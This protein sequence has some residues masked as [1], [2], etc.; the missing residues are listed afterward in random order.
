MRIRWLP[1]VG[2]LVLAC[3][4][5]RAPS[6][7]ASTERNASY[8]AALE[9]ISTEE[10]QRHVAFLADEKREGREAGT[11]GGY[12]AGEYLCAQLE[13]LGLAGAGTDG[14]Y[15]QAFAPNYRNILAKLEGSD[16]ALHAEVIVVGA[17]YDHIGLGR[18]GSASGEVG[19][20]HPGA[21]DN[22]SGTS[23]LLE[24]AQ[25]LTLAP[26]PRRTLVLAF[27]DA[28]EKG[29]LGSKYWLAHPTVRPDQV[30]LLINLDMIGRL[31][32]DQLLVYGTRSGYGLRRLVSSHNPAPGLI[33]DF[34]WAMQPNADHFPFFSRDIPVLTFHTGLHE[35]YHRPSDKPEL[36]NAAGMRR[37]ARL[38]F[39]VTYD[40]ANRPALP[41]FRPAARHENED[42]RR[43]LSQQPPQ[44][45][46]RLGASWEAD[47]AAPRAVRLTG[48]LAHSPA[49]R[50]GLRPGDQVVEFAGR[51]IRSADDLTGA[52]AMAPVR[53]SARV[54]RLGHQQPV[55]IPLELNEKPFRIGIVWRSDDAE[56]GIAV[57]SYVVPGSPAAWAGLQVEDR[58]EQI[59]GRDFADDQELIR[60][61]NELP[62]P[63][64][65]RVERHGQ[66]RTLE[67]RL[68]P[69][70]LRRA[71]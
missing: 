3:V 9:S 16:R 52:V 7:A 53:T 60:L 61:L 31:R 2:W 33:L 32:N 71:A 15:I 70:A 24:L 20:V 25:A 37:V 17:H 49:D 63:I 23:A 56:P 58:I 55:E 10:L 67:L 5:T 41:A 50:A 45:A 34:S 64:R 39:A 19:M 59:N 13:A 11:P 57:V 38:V 22:A 26:S 66:V 68:E 47:P 69:K 6:P 4:V 65:L 1:T 12:A 42:T 44:L 46:D 27:W 48:I 30:K 51:E 8:R 62:S 36:I 21:D 29:M 18:K 54:L 40:L 35:Q 14:A 28:E 43:S